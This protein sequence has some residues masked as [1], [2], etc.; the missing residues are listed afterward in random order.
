MKILSDQ[1]ISGLLGG[2]SIALIAYVLSKRSG[3]KKRL[4][5]ERQKVVSNSAKALSWNVTFVVILIAWG[6]TII[7]DGISF[8][9]FLLTGIYVLHCLSLMITSVYYS[10]QNQ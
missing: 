6:V 5:D 9:F 10:N 8:Y 3:K 2:V 1:L 7:I 4:F